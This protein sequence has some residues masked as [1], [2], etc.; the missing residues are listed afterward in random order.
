MYCLAW[1]FVGVDIRVVS[2][3]ITMWSSVDGVFGSHRFIFND[4]LKTFTGASR[5]FVIPFE[6]FIQ[7]L[8][9]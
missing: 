9:K 6:V 4:F 8:F 7:A 2:A 5:F 3:Q 1:Y